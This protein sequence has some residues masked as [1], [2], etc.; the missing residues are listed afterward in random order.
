M[1]KIEITKKE[2]KAFKQSSKLITTI[3]GL[4][5]YPGVAEDG[6][7][8]ITLCNVE[9]TPKNNENFSK[10]G[11]WLAISNYSLQSLEERPA[12]FTFDFNGT[13]FQGTINLKEYN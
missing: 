2:L 3:S 10:Y 8:P 6:T 11:A 13:L 5:N 4:P 12:L 1:L 7:M 9:Y